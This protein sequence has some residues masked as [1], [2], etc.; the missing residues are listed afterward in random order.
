MATAR[1]LILSSFRLVGINQPS[2]I[3][4]DDALVSLNN[5]ISN[6]SVG[7]LN[8]HAV[9]TEN[10]TLVTDQGTYT[11]GSGGDFDTVR[12]TKIL[13]SVYI[14]DSS[15]EDYPVIPMSRQQYNQI[16]SKIDTGRPTRIYYEPEYPLGKIR[17][18]YLPSTAETLYIDSWK[19]ITEIATLATSINLPVEYKR[20]LQ[21]NLAIELVEEPSKKIGQLAY[22]TLQ[23]IKNNNSSDRVDDAVFDDY[24]TMS[25][26][27]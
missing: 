19:P 5:L 3:Q 23:A 15:G 7:N 25:F 8:L 27:R 18:N 20:A 12:P 6:L 17:F 26:Y 10:F 13:D 16:A 11:I 21:Y 1:E 14:K 9:T 24:L 22:S 2:S 4:L